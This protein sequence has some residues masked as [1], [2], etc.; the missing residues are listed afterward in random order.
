MFNSTI[1]LQNQYLNYSF[2]FPRKKVYV[3]Y[4]HA[5]NSFSADINSLQ[6]DRS[7]RFIMTGLTK[8]TEATA[9]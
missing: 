5:R 9:V 6:A 8:Y 3:F 7:K 2:G 4:L 1:L